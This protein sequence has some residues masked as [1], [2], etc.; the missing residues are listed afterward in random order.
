MPARKTVQEH[1]RSFKEAYAGVLT[2]IKD[3]VDSVDDEDITA[4]EEA[5]V[6]ANGIQAISGI[7]VGVWHELHRIAN[8]LQR[9][10]KH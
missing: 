1:E 3:V 6:M 2:C 4:E 8:S 10:E 9:M 7:G 5:A